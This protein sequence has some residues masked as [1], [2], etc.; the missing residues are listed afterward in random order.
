MAKS[1][2]EIREMGNND[3]W[4][5]KKEENADVRKE[6]KSAT[7]QRGKD[8][9]LWQKAMGKYRQK[10]SDKRVPSDERND[11]ETAS[12]SRSLS[13]LNPQGH[14]TPLSEAEISRKMK[15]NLSKIISSQEKSCQTSVIGIEA[16]EVQT[17][18][19]P[20][21]SVVETGTQSDMGM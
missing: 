3:V 19:L 7:Q 15:E 10:Y 18:S 1:A 16:K 9:V 11:D 8:K 6:N 20:K 17:S 13:L 2:I 21:K 12:N 4:D 14:S 5:N